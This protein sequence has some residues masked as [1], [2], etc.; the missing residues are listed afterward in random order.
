MSFELQ[1]T[2]EERGALSDGGH[3]VHFRAALDTELLTDLVADRLI[4]FVGPPTNT[5]RSRSKGETGLFQ[6]V[7]RGLNRLLDAVTAIS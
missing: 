2:G 5:M 7:A 3:R 1:S 4:A 6:G